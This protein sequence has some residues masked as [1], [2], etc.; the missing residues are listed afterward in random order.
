MLFLKKYLQATNY[1]PTIITQSIKGYCDNLGLIQLVT[2]MQTSTIPN[3][4][5][6][7]SNDYELTSE[8]FQTIQCIPVKIILLHI[9][10]HQDNNTPKED[11]PDPAQ[12]NVKCKE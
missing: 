12:L 10:G 6:A 5:H 4:S 11:L 7:I 8:I 9:Q 3:P 1:L 2:S